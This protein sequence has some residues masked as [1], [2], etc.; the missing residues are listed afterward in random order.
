MQIKLNNPL[1][2]GMPAE[3]NKAARILTSFIKGNGKPMDKIDRDV[4]PPKVLQNAKGVAV[5]SVLKAGFLWSGRMGSGL[6]VARL[7]DV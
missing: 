6:V 5:I 3:C 2:K 4:I 7:P 1:P